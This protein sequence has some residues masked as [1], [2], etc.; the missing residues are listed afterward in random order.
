[1]GDIADYCE[2]CDKPL[3]IQSTEEKA[4]SLQCEFCGK[5][6]TSK[7]Y[8]PNNHYICDKCHSNKGV[9]KIQ[10]LCFNSNEKNPYILAETIM[11]DIVFNMYGPEH[12]VLVPTVILAS[13]RNN[14]ILKPDGNQISK[15]DIN[16]AIKR[17]SKIPG[18][19]CGYYGTCGA[20][21]GAGI[22]LSIFLN[23]TPS[24]D[25]PRSTAN[26]A[27]SRALLSIADNLEHCCKRSVKY[28]I[29]SAFTTLKNNQKI[30]LS[31]TP[32]KCVFSMINTK[33]SKD[34]CPFYLNSVF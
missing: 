17:A 27:T 3:I 29:Q 8:C 16:N 21:I 18:G 22:A 24:T 30:N 13:L 32:S 33:C 31:F 34:S 26:N 15:N 6:F 2:I 10:Q 28:G 20:G 19:W 14:N 1:M 7:I 11:N 5:I 23:A 25:L 4:I 9:L 12:H